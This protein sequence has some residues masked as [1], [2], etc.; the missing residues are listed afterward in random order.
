MEA[1]SIGTD[2]TAMKE[3][4]VQLQRAKES[5]EFAHEQLK[6]AQS[7]L[8]SQAHRAGMAE[9]TTSALHNI[10]N[11]LTSVIA[12]AEVIHRC[13]TD[14]KL[15]KYS[16]AN[17]I[18][19]DQSETKVEFITTDPRG[20]TLLDYYLELEPVLQG[21][22]TE[23]IHSAERLLDKINIIREAIEA[24]Q[25]FS[26]LGVETEELDVNRVLKDSIVIQNELIRSHS[27]TIERDFR[28][29]PLINVNRTKLLHV[30]LNLV[31]SSCEALLST[32]SDARRL[33][34]STVLSEDAIHIEFAD[35]G[36]GIEES[37]LGRVFDKGYSRKGEGPG[38]GLHSCNE[39]VREMG[40]WMR[41]ESKGSGKGATFTVFFPYSSG[42]E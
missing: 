21:E 29:M 35:N 23:I 9:A 10:G 22:N 8:V 37:E 42:S 38:L 14:T 20:Q 3:T 18:L 31:K 17:Q 27:V 41:A 40:G 6:Q 5:A 26:G 1:L 33:A 7:E 34:I 28:A 32:A 4:R 2:I 12:S 39:F 19:R 30:F 16:E 15:A 11:V 25:A 13:A 36:S 24:Q